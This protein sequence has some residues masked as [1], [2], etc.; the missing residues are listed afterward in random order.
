MRI[1]SKFKLLP[2]ASLLALGVAGQA[3]A[4]PVAPKP[5][6]VN[7]GTVHFTGEIV[8]AACAVDN[9]FDGQT[10]K[11]GQFRAGALTKKGDHSDVVPFTIKLTD[12]EL[13]GDATTAAYSTVAV[14][15]SGT[16]AGSDTKSI[17]VSGASD[18]S[19]NTAD[20][21]KNVGVEI[22][23]DGTPLSIDGTTAATAQSIHA[24]DNTLSF[25]AAYVAT[26]D[27]A[28]AGIANADATFKLTY[29]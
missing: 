21:A 29:E 17:A 13:G 26:A 22:L 6:T 23:Q 12:C 3:M 16:Q 4:D 28:T 9:D 8:N 2:L 18:G 19:A 20:A 14:T 7:G 27:K 10:V 15:F 5:V 25:G 24:G 1:F 11:L